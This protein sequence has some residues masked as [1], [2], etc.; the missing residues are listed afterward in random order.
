MVHS[1][2]TRRADSSATFAA[3]R[4]FSN[5][6]G[7]LPHA[8]ISPGRPARAAYSHSASVGRR[9]PALRQKAS[10]SSHVTLTTGKWSSRC[11]G[12]CSASAA[13]APAARNMP[14]VTSVA[15]SANDDNVTWC[16]GRSSSAQRGS[17]GTHPI[18]NVP[19]GMATHSM[20]R[21]W[22][23]RP[24]VAVSSRSMAAMIASADFQGVARTLL[25][26][27]GEPLAGSPPRTPA[28]WGAVARPTRVKSALRIPDDRAATDQA[29]VLEFAV[30]RFDLRGWHHVRHDRLDL[31]A[32]DELGAFGQLAL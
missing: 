30:D 11:Q 27:R 9:P 1:G 18:S 25:G 3:G 21:F 13:A 24:T 14:A 5:G 17:S 7:A 31:A 12:G 28:R 16:R 6:A 2:W 20:S 22:A 19:A 29:A 15:V 26:S 4:A 32:G 23:V 10:A 8:W